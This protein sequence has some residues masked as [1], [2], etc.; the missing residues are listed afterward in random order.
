MKERRMTKK[1]TDRWWIARGQPGYELHSVE[2]L[3]QLTKD[4]T[5]QQLQ[6]DEFV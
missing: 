3:T 1:R 2:V 4:E 5:I 6:A